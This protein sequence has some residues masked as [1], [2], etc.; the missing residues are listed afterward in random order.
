MHICCS[1]IDMH[2]PECVSGYAYTDPSTSKNQL[3]D[4]AAATCPPGYACKR[5]TL[6]N[7]YV[8]CTAQMDNRYEG[9]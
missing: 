8:C 2:T 9:G 3:C 1:S 6:A 7:A 5:S 4:P